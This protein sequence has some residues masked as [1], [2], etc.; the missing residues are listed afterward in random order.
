M[1]VGV[2][3]LTRH[4]RSLIPA[5]RDKRRYVIMRLID[6]TGE[7]LFLAG[8]A[9]F[10][11]R[12]VRLDPRQ[13]SL[14][15]AVAGAVGILASGAAGSLAGRFGTKRTMLLAYSLSTLVYLGYCFFRSFPA[16][17]LLTC[18]ASAFYFFSGAAFTSYVST[19]AAEQ[20]RTRLRAQ[21]R[22][23]I[24][25]GFG[26]GA[27]LAALVLA[28]DTIPAFYLLPIGNAVSFL[29]IAVLITSLPE[30]DRA[31]PGAAKRLAQ[32]FPARR[33]LPFLMATALNAILQMHDTL[34]LLIVPLWIVSRTSA[35]KALIGVLLVCNTISGVLLQVRASR[36]TESLAGS[37]HKVRLAAAVMVPGCL[38]VALSGHTSTSLAVLCL[39]AGYASF[40]ATELLQSAGEW[41]ILDTLVPP[42]AMADYAGV[43]G[44]SG[45][46]RDVLGPGIGGWLVLTYGT[47]GWVILG[48]I[49]V[50]A[51]G[52]QGVVVSRAALL[53]ERRKAEVTFRL[54]IVQLAQADRTPDA[55]L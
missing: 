34:I 48:L 33:N 20:E 55:R 1:T 12:V 11:I 7:G 23:L 17:L 44:M 31:A 29:A 46:A 14:C 22:S 40:T 32:P 19:I 21:S 24:N 16:F 37:I 26:I 36:G 8:I 35:P 3:V 42:D 10:A 4:V 52:L 25:A 38:A 6:A 27:A 50:V 39:I 51:A 13:I 30:D 41:G 5:E 15:F 9:V 45:A 43:F 54:S 49:T 53:L 47:G 28:I 18:L 2:G